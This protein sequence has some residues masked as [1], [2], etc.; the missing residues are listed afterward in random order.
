MI[1][2]RKIV[3]GRRNGGKGKGKDGWL[4]KMTDG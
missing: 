3:E 1:K 4:D 2:K